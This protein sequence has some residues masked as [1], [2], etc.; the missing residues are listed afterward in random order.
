MAE[1]ESFFGKDKIVQILHQF[2]ALPSRDIL[3]ELY[4]SVD[5]FTGAQPQADD[6]TGILVKVS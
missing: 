4:Q 5:E 1:D 6:L 3:Q 2:R